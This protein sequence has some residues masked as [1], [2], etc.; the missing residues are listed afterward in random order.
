MVVEQNANKCP[1]NKNATAADFEI[2][3]SALCDSAASPKMFY[4]T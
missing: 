4:S 3:V 1:I 2:R